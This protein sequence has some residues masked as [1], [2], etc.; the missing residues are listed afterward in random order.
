MKR[1]STVFLTLSIATILSAN[2]YYCSPSGSGNGNSYRTPCSFQ[3]GLNKL[4]SPG[5][6]LYLLAG[7]YNLGNTHISGKNGTA[8]T[9]IVISGYPGEQAILDFRTT[10]YGTR[11]LQIE[12]SCTYIHVKDLTLRYSGK[13]NLYNAG[14]FCLFERLDIYGSSDTGCQMKGGGNNIIKNVDS[15]DNFDYE[16]INGSGQA[17]YGG[18]ADGFADKQFTGAGNHYIGC[19]A[20]NN[21]DDG[22]DFFQRVSNSETIIED[23][24]CYQNGPAEYNMLNHPRYQ[25]DKTW[26]DQINGTTV[27]SRYGEQVLVTLEHYP[28]MGN[29]N[30]FKLG[31]DYT[32]HNVLIHHCL[33]IANTVRGFDQNN[34]EGQMRVYNNTGYDNGM[35]FGFY[36]N[37]GV[38]TIRNNVSFPVTADINT[39]SKTTRANDHNTW[40]QS[41]GVNLTATDFQSFDTTQV[42]LPRHA[43]GTRADST[44]LRLSANSDLINAGIDVGLAYNGSA[45]DLGCFE[46]AGE[47][48]PPKPVTGHKVAWVSLG[49][50]SDLKM[51]NRLNDNDS[52]ALIEVSANE[53][54]HDFSQYEAIVLS[55][56]PNSGCAAYTDLKG[57]NRPMLVLKPFLF[58][59]SVWNWGNAVNTQDLSV[60]VTNTTHPIFEGISLNNG[61]L[62][63]FSA[64]TTN[65]VT[66]VSAWTNASGQVEIASPVGQPTYSSITEFPVGSSVGG[67][68]FTAPLLMIGLSE[69]STADLTDAAL[70]LLENAVFYLLDLD[71]PSALEQLPA[72]DT[73]TKYLIDNQLIIELRGIKYSATGQRL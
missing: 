57:Y 36:S 66:A 32:Q 53:S 26:F 45:P 70:Q 13:N 38:L 6:T 40:N 35:N 37:S 43:D 20:W 68:T 14:S 58:K 1:I 61:S 44:L 18:N 56:A 51:F 27:T 33:A 54:G 25:T 28:N 72:T 42:L 7:Q 62:Q 22:W 17:D 46:S 2:T 55:P 3:N 60:S 59:A 67:T 29:G 19:R 11:G 15:H 69:Y 52:L 63:L 71:Y 5:D 41:T 34:N 31:G 8:G 24:I 47:P 65:A 50:V 49:S 64:C 21:S 23:C 12:S 39:L 4:T 16:H 48:A 9:Y 10:A 30:G 73:A